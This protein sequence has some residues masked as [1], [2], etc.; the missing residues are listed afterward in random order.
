MAKIRGMWHVFSPHRLISDLY[1]RN[2]FEVLFWIDLQVTKFW[3]RLLVW[4][5][6]FEYI[7]RRTNLDAFCDGRWNEAILM[8]SFNLQLWLEI[9]I[10]SSF[11]C[12]GDEA[13]CYDGLMMISIFMMNFSLS[14]KWDKSQCHIKPIKVWDTMSWVL[15]TRQWDEAVYV[16]FGFLWMFSNV[17]STDD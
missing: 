7:R 9:T 15:Y 6:L 17:A 3:W 1:D 2:Q 5:L 12:L 11:T 16:W 10:T 4:E 14:M 13:S 8:L